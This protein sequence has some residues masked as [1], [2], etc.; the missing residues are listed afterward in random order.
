MP[1][2]FGNRMRRKSWDDIDP[3][4]EDRNV[5]LVF[6]SLAVI[7]AFLGLFMW[8]MNHAPHR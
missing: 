5:L 3:K 2:E 7:M 4:T 6:L 8:F 1:Y